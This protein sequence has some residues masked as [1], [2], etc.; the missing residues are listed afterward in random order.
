MLSFS[1]LVAWQQQFEEQRGL[2]EFNNPL[3]LVQRAKTELD[4]LEHALQNGHTSEE[5]ASEVAD[6]IIFMAAI[7]MKLEIENP[8]D[9][10][11]AKMERNQSKYAVEYFLTAEHPQVAIDMARE[12]W[13]GD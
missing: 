8:D 12:A 1:E 3:L 7:I 11:K 4:E 6:V 2:L 5:K 10:I 9:I 13:K